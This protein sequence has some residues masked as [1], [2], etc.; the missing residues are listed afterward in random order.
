MLHD[1]HHGRNPTKNYLMERNRLIFVSTAYSLRLLLLVSPVLVAAELGLLAVAAREG[2]FGD[3]LSGW[4][5]CLANRGW[6][7]RHR[8]ALQ[9]GRRVS[10]RELAQWLTPVVDPGMVSVP[11]LVRAG[12]P[13]LRGYWALARRLL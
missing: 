4:R 6:I 9:N 12:N 8:R 2:W 10:D 3:K 13:L 1:Y 5:W 11:A 7:R